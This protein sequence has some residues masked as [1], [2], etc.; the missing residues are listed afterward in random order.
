MNRIFRLVTVTSL[1]FFTATTWAKDEAAEALNLELCERMLG[2][3]LVSTNGA[4]FKFDLSKGLGA[5][6]FLGSFPEPT[7][8]NM[9]RASAQGVMYWGHS[10]A[11]RKSA[12]EAAHHD[13]QFNGLS[14]ILY[15]ISNV[16]VSDLK[17]DSDPAEI[18]SRFVKI[19]ETS[20]L[21]YFDMVDGSQV[22]RKVPLEIA[23]KL[24]HPK[25][26]EYFT[27]DDRGPR[28]SQG[29]WTFPQM[30]GVLTYKNVFESGSN[31][32]K[33][34]IKTAR[35]LENKGYTISFNQNFKES[36]DKARDQVRLEKLEGGGLKAVPDGSR[37]TKVPEYQMAMD[38][39]AK[40]HNVSVEVRDPSGRLLAGIIGQHHGNIWAFDTIFYNFVTRDGSRTL[41]SAELAAMP[42]AREAKS[43]IDLAKV[44]AL[45]ALLRLHDH[46]IDV[47]DAG[48]VTVFTAGLKGVY[49][50]GVEFA[51]HV[52]DLSSRPLIEV[53][54]KTP[55]SFSTR[56]AAQ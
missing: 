32:I 42:D 48:M 8:D 52:V 34:V 56:A 4:D 33:N 2:H 45:A 44:A 14:K 10:M 7:A 28:F 24:I 21:I 20:D 5:R 19:F 9:V 25:T 43:L 30:R 46:G 22:L 40:G 18:Q 6:G 12:I 55:F 17:D 39:Y 49:I 41:T 54:L 35:G 36:L 26:I 50:P 27:K 16:D 3:T 37:Y 13:T 51:Q 38:G 31:T 47:S 23:R 29:G 53:D 15:L 1:I 11:V